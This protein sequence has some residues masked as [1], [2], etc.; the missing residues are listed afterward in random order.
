MFSPDVWLPGNSSI[1]LESGTLS[2]RSSRLCGCDEAW[3]CQ[4]TSLAAEVP[5]LLLKP[6]SNAQLP[7]M[8]A[9]TKRFF[10]CICDEHRISVSTLYVDMQTIEPLWKVKRRPLSTFVKRIGVKFRG[11]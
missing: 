8:R 11:L 4:N 2:L 7:R 6:D 10:E 5:I 3:H 9:V 1:S